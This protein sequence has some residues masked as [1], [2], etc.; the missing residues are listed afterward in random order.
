MTANVTG[1]HIRVDIAFMRE[2]LP[3]IGPY[4][5]TIYAVIMSHR[6]ARTGNCF[7][8]YKTIARESKTDRSTVIR[9]VKKLRALNLIDPQWRFKED[10]SHNSNQYNFDLSADRQDKGG[11]RKPEAVVAQDNSGSRP[12]PPELSE[13]NRKEKRT[14][15]TGDSHVTPKKQRTLEEIDFMPTEKQKTCNHPYELISYLP[16][17]I[18]ICYHCWGL[19]DE[20]L[21]L[22]E[23]EK[24]PQ[25]QAA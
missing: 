22:I 5:F 19:L 18:R 4:G 15:F 1:S 14:N 20:N 11:G 3:I 16:D 25:A 23:E 24:A 21:K 2:Y 9:Y 10:G 17:N 8:S 6:N 13:S 7:P 12:E